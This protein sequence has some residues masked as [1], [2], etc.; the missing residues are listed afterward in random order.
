[1]VASRD[2]GC[3]SS[4]LVQKRNNCIFQEQERAAQTQIDNLTGQL[5]EEDDHV[6][7]LKED[8]RIKEEELS[9][10]KERSFHLHKL[11]EQFPILEHQVSQWKT[12]D[13]FSIN[14]YI[15][16]LFVMNWSALYKAW[17]QNSS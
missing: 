2:V 14:V 11:Q 6:Q 10:L 7:K 13:V 12:K 5:R 1:M 17:K 9:D 15:R 8:I 16:L 3:F 4:F